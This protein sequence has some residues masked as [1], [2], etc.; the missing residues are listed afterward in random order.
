MFLDAIPDPPAEPFV[1]RLVCSQ[2]K[3]RFDVR[4]VKNPTL[5]SV[6]TVTI[7]CK[8]C[9]HAN[10]VPIDGQVAANGEWSVDWPA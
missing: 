1:K 9:Q 3:T 7:P 4:Y 8:K 6:Y 5:P 10:R 2:C